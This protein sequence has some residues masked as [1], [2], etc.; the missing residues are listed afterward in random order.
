VSTAPT[1]SSAPAGS[2]SPTDPWATVPASGAWRAGDDPGDRRFVDVFVDRPLRLEHGGTIGPVTVA[3]ETWG[4]RR[5]DD[6]NAVLVLHALT[7]DSHLSGPAGA[8]HSSPGWWDAIVG[9]GAALDPARWWTVCPNVLGGCQGT[10]GP[11]SLHPDGRPWGPRFPALTVRD[12]VSVELALADAL[13]VR[14]WALVVGG[15]MGGMRAMEWA[16]VAPQRVER[17]AIIACGA[18][19]SAEQIA[20]CAVQMDA[21]RLDPGFAG[22]DYYDAPAGAG[23]G[24][25]LGLGRRIG[26]I[27]YRSETELARRF[28]R[29]PQPGED[30]GAG[31]RYAVESYLDHQALKLARRFDA[32]SYLTLTRAMDH[33]D[34]GRDRGGAA[35]ALAR[36][37]AR[38]T[39][40]GVDTDRLYPIRLQQELVELLPGRPALQVITSAAGHDGF[41]IETEQVDRVVAGALSD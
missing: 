7:A 38:V 33:H 31:G 27:T 2:P 1:V 6:T 32:N 35:A 41:L 14:R 19:A 24:R 36:V 12:Q 16:I 26:H 18:A 22:G 23:P 34:I 4:T 15:S 8:A 17:A 3:Y 40:A 25:G 13:G 37:S 21:I 9:P 29:M 11:S 10:T 30:P 5:P 39:V 20:M 28:G